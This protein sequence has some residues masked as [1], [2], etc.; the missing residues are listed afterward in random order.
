MQT[1][2]VVLFLSN[3]L[4]G[5]GEY[6]LIVTA[7]IKHKVHGFQ[8]LLCAVWLCVLLECTPAFC[9]CPSFLVQGRGGVKSSLEIASTMVLSIPFM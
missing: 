6:F 1:F 5:E 8:M 4:N 7:I 2:V 9:E 3:F